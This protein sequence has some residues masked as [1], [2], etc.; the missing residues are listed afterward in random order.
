MTIASS[1]PTPARQQTI[2]I[3]FLSF[4]GLGMTSGLLGLAWPSMQKQFNLPLDGV[5]SILLAQTIS[6]TIASFS[7]GRIMVR[8]GS[9]PTLIIGGVLMTL[10]MFGIA[11]S[12]SWL[13][14]I[15]FALLYGLGSGIIDAALNFYVAAYHSAQQMSWLHA[16]FGIGVTIGPLVMTFALGQTL[17]WQLGYSIT[18]ALLLIVVVLLFISRKWWRNDGFQSAD[19]TPVKTETFAASLRV[20]AVWLSI[21]TFLAYVGMEVGIGQWAY[22]ILTESRGMATEVAGPWVS[23]YWGSFTIGRI[24]F[25]VIANRFPVS[26]ILQVCMLVIIVSAGLFFWNPT[27]AVG[28]IGL[29]ILGF[30]QAPVFPMF[31]AG[32]SK[33]VGATHA[34]NAISLQMGGVGLGTAILPGLIGTIGKNFGL[35]SMALVFFI[36]SIIVFALHEFLRTRPS[37][38][39][40]APV[41]TAA[42]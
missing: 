38:A 25:G 21:A 8:L 18:G 6:Y 27:N 20:P 7:I 40:I 34:A 15:A 11:F 5:T 37:Q 10:C 17:G 41:S 4:I 31:M 32:T 23:I 39:I 19:N 2:G 12:Q 16:S 30:A 28:L 42:D 13:S 29:I 36:L 14:V 1:V 33:R 35:E 26:R 22:T 24:L 3:A 9:G